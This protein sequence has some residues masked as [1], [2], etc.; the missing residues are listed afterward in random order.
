M[1]FAYLLGKNTGTHR[2]SCAVTFHMSATQTNSLTCE[3]SESNSRIRIYCSPVELEAGKPLWIYCHKDIS[4]TKQRQFR[5]GSWCRV[6]ENLAQMAWLM[7]CTKQHKDPWGSRPQ[8]LLLYSQ[9]YMTHMAL[10]TSAVIQTN[11]TGHNE[12]LKTFC[13]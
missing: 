10:Q 11:F 13:S 12:V 9:H 6:S 7:A 4:Q 3:M 2:S 1:R 8:T 5:W